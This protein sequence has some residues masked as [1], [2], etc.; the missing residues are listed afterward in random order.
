MSAAAETGPTLAGYISHHL[1]N[2]ASTKQVK[3]IDF[4]IIHYDTV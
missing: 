4:S 1:E 3:M 2:L